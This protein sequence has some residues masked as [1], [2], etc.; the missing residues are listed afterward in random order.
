MNNDSEVAHPLSGSLSALADSW[1]NWTLEKFVLM[2]EEER[3]LEYR[4]KTS[5]SK[6]ENQQQTQPSYGVDAG[7]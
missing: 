1:S 5:R 3:K 7:N 4:R 6:G 2:S